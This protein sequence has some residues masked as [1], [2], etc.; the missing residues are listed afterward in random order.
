M[1]MRIFILQKTVMLDKFA[2][3]HQEHQAEDCQKHRRKLFFSRISFYETNPR[4]VSIR[5]IL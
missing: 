3:F 4:Q 2:K 5:E 1:Q